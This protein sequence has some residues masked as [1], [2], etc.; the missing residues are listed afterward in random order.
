MIPRLSSSSLSCKNLNVAHYS[1]S[2]KGIKSGL[3]YLLIMSKCSGRTRG[4][5]LKAVIFK[6]K[7]LIRMMDPD[8]QAVPYGVVHLLICMDDLFIHNSQSQ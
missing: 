2:I 4:R 7:F 5:T 6:L 3:E 1:K 8:R